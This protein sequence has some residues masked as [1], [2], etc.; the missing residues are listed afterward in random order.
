MKDNVKVVILDDFL[1]LVEL[2]FDRDL[3]L[4]L[5]IVGY[6]IYIFRGGE[7]FFEIKRIK[8]IFMDWIYNSDFEYSGDII[9]FMMVR[10]FRLFD[11]NF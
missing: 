7:F 2:N 5:D 9:K 10:E 1:Y 11:L 3:V 8:V 4:Y 6:D